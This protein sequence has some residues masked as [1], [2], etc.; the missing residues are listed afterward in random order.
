[1]KNQPRHVIRLGVFGLIV[2]ALLALLGS[3]ASV[4]EWR[5]GKR[6]WP[7]SA[8]ALCGNS[9]PSALSLTVRVGL[10]EEFPIPWR[11]DKL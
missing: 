7:W 10:Y 11:L 9:K 6:V 3:N 2:L 1:M 8:Y 4:R 5:T